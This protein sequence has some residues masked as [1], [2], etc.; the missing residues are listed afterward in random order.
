M[1]VYK[2]EEV[3]TKSQKL[4]KIKRVW[5]QTKT[6]HNDFGIQIYEVIMI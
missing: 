5:I 1:R 2:N 4:R 6:L 3:N